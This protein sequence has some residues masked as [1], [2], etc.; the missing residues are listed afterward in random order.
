M[1]CSLGTDCL[2]EF[3]GQVRSLSDGLRL[4]HLDRGSC[5]CREL[6]PKF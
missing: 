1:V 6:K 5:I 4:L 2:E 3:S